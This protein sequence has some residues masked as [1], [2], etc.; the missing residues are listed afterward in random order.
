[1]KVVIDTSSLLSL[2]RY[3]LRFDKS[4]ILFEFVKNKIEIGEIIIID[5]IHEE[6]SY[7]SSGLVLKTLPYLTDKAFLKSTKLPLKTDSLIAPAPSKF[8]RM[9]DSHF[10]NATV[11]KSK[12][13]TNA[14]YE[15]QKNAFMNDAD[16]KL[17]LLC[18]NLIKDNQDEEVILIIF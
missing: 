13:L 3:Y 5:K 6:C 12:N 2:V 15:T 4:S 1:M 9:V 11:R 8:S 17:I 18:L 14:E 16:M 10:V 7:S